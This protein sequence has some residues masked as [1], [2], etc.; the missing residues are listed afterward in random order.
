MDV[1][2]LAVIAIAFLILIPIIV[3]LVLYSSL[4]LK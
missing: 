3:L 4:P 1:N 2:I